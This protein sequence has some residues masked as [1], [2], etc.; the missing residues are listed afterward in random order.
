[1]FYVSTMVELS[2]LYKTIGSKPFVVG[3]L[4]ELYLQLE[5]SIRL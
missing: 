5:H 1:V 4:W 3:V 2:S